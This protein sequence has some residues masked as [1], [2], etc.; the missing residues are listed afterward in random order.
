MSFDYQRDT[1][2]T[3]AA[4]MVDEGLRQYMLKIY[5][6]MT[7]GLLVTAFVSYGLAHSTLAA[8]FFKIGRAH[9]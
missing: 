9:V 1:V 7:L 6:Y 4:A 2:V 3:R 5:N 8:L